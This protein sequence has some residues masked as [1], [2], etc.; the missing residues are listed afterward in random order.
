MFGR[1]PEAEEWPDLLDFMAIAWVDADGYTL[2]ERLPEAPAAA[3]RWPLEAL[4]GLWVVDG[5]EG[6]QALLRDIATEAEVAVFAPGANADLTRRTI[7][8][9]RVVPW[10]QSWVFLGE[11]GLYGEHGVIA[12]QQLLA[13]WRDSP[14]PE[15]IARMRTLRHAFAEQRDQQRAFV[16]YFGSD[17]LLCPDADTLERRLNAFLDNYHFATALPRL[18]GRTPAEAYAATTGKTAQ[19]IELRI[20]PTLRDGGQPAVVYDQVRGVQFWPSFGELRA[21]LAGTTNT[22]AVLDLY[23]QETEL[24]AFALHR[25][26]LEHTDVLAAALAVAPAAL[27]LALENRKPAGPDPAFCPD[28]P[29]P[30]RATNPHAATF[31][32][33]SVAV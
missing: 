20:G 8:R 33:T 32:H 27:V 23:L 7:L 29:T 18:G 12:R 10:A 6:E 26:C 15:L 4:D 21:H 22:P 9:A 11:P 19:R 24:P 3:L 17:E 28:W 13:A 14:E 31:R 16:A 25:A 30:A 1:A 5:W 2:V